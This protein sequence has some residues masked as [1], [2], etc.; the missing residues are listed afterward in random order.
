MYWLGLILIGIFGLIIGSFI[1]S[2][3]YR[4]REKITVA[5]GRSFCPHC[6][7]DISWYDNIPL[8][9]YLVLSGKCR[10]C[11]KNIDLRYPLIELAT[12]L[13]FVLIFITSQFCLS[14]PL[15]YWQDKIGIFAIPYFLFVSFSLIAIFITDIEDQIIPDSLSFLLFTFVASALLVAN[16]EDIYA[17]LFTG[18][19][20][21]LVFLLLHIITLGRGMGLGDVKLVLF[22]GMFFGWKLS[23]LWVFMSFVIGALVG[24]GLIVAGKAKFGKQIAFGPFLV[25]SFFVTIFAG[26]YILAKLFPYL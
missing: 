20:L 8:I 5:K 7:K 14:S 1:A 25:V 16:P 26:D 9:S 17:R 6:K 21:S 18:F 10:N 13:V 4:V 12:A 22:A 24:V 15:C 23:L 3:T 11:R 19:F 2:Y